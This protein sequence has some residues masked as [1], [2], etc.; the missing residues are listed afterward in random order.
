[1][2]RRNIRIWIGGRATPNSHILDSEQTSKTYKSKTTPLSLFL[3][4]AKGSFR[5][6]SLR[7][8]PFIHPEHY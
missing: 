1:M 2:G 4:M 8:V 7:N 6:K 5:D 3:A